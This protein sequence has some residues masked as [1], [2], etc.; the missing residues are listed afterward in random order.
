MRND[1]I[2]EIA[3]A[4]LTV[5]FIPLFI[6]CAPGS[7]PIGAAVLPD[8]VGSAIDRQTRGLRRR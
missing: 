7:T 8:E 6:L 4:L 3:L 1:A 2:G 5:L